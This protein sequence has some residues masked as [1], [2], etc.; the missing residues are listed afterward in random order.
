[1]TF[2]QLVSSHLIR[3]RKLRGQF[4]L[5]LL[6]SLLVSYGLV[7]VNSM[8]EGIQQRYVMLGD[9]EITVQGAYPE[10]EQVIL[11]SA[12]IY[13]S[14]SVRPIAL[15][16]VGDSYFSA[17]RRA[18]LRSLSR[19]EEQDTHSVTLGRT[20]ANEL[21]LKL[22]DKALVVIAIGDSFRPM[23]CKVG[24]I[25]DSGYAELDAN[26]AF[27]PSKALEPYGFPVQTELVVGKGLEQSLRQIREEGYS[28]RA[29]YEEEDDLVENLVTSRKLILVIFCVII[30]LGAY[31]ASEFAS[32]LVYDRRRD[33]ALL[34]LLG[35]TRRSI[36]R[37][38]IRGICL[39]ESMAVFLGLV[40]GILLS[41]LSR[42]LLG[43]ISDYGFPSLTYY[44]LTFTIRIPLG[45][46]ALVAL[47][48]LVASV[49]SAA[50]GIRGIRKIEPLS[51]VA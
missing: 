37:A 13:G 25:Y 34:S 47:L 15:K 14:S 45:Q 3:E 12:L 4:V 1:M 38:F 44:L 50:I 17:G 32:V 9:G 35:S 18:A 39:L 31:F 6:I 24:G 10:G 51:L 23:L 36:T 42:P 29:W 2:Q 27:L 33:I 22:G 46:L 48:L 49:V 16:G 30:L 19:L 5:L 28:A 26:L 41:F 43:A 8:V 20:L 40:L 7:F 11:A 21:D